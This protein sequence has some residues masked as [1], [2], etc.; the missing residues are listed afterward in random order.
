MR[1][2][3]FDRNSEVKERD[4]GENW[5]FNILKMAMIFLLMSD[6]KKVNR[7]LVN[8]FFFFFVYITFFF[9]VN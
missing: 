9:F 7:K 4:S 3:F 8:F 6:K 5:F 2:D 1:R